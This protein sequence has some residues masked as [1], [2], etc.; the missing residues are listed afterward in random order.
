MLL[1]KGGSYEKRSSRGGR[2]TQKTFTE[3]R[4]RC[5]SPPGTILS[6]S[7]QDQTRNSPALQNCADPARRERRVRGA[8][9]EHRA[10]T[11]TTFKWVS[12]AES[13]SDQPCTSPEPFRAAQTPALPR[14]CSA[15]MPMDTVI[16]DSQPGEHTRYLWGRRRCFE[17]ADGDELSEPCKAKRGTPGTLQG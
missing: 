12:G 3:G 1:Q 11:I 6:S 7:Q 14:G 15:C 4:S 2:C 13:A 16:N 5:W 17:G 8:T 9:S 10:A